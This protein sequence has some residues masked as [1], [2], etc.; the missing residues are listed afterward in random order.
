MRRLLAVTVALSAAVALAA[1]SSAAK[2]TTGPRVIR[3]ASVDLGKK[4]I[5][6]YGCGTCHE[7]PGVD[8]AKGLVAAPLTH[9]GRRGTIAGRLANTPDNLIRWVEDPQDVEPGTD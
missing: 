8:G 7:I 6:R 9:F 3:G 1:C 5:V 2:E 4:L